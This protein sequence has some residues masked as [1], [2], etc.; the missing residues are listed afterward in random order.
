MDSIYTDFT[1]NVLCEVNVFDVF[2]A[3][4]F[5]G[6]FVAGYSSS[7]LHTQASIMCVGRGGG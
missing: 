1:H 6:R 5:W 7:T 3:V 4:R 2:Q